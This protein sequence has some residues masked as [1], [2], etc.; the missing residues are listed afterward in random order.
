MRC[1]FTNPAN[2]S[3]YDFEINP[4]GMEPLE[5]QRNVE[6]TAP[7]SGVGFV[8]QQGSDSPAILTYTGKILSQDQRDQMQVYYNLSAGQTIHFRDWTGNVFQ[9]LVTTFNPKRERTAKNPRGGTEAATH[10]WSYTLSL[11]VI[12]IVSGKMP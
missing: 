2:G 9:V 7:T 1:R 5:Q 6:R 3:F 10:Y 8:R 4:D 11:E 12:S